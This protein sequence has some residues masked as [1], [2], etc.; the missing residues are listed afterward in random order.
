MILKKSGNSNACSGGRFLGNQVQAILLFFFLSPFVHDLVRWKWH[1]NGN[2]GLEKCTVYNMTVINTCCM[3]FLKV[4]EESRSWEFSSQRKNIFS[5]SFPL[6][7]MRWWMLAR[8]V[9][10]FI[11]QYTKVHHSYLKLIQSYMYI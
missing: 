1:W 8:P 4:V 3:V 2:L 10:A 7:Y 6:T 5:F 11:L 9:V